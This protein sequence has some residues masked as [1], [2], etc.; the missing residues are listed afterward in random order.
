M[1][2]SLSLFAITGV[3]WRLIMPSISRSGLVFATEMRGPSAHPQQSPLP[4]EGTDLG[5]HVHARKTMWKFVQVLS[6]L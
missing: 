4:A 5:M 1:K 6:T 3:Y 2:P